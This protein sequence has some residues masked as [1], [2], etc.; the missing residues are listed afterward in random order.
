MKKIS[1]H[2]KNFW[3]NVI[4]G[5]LFSLGMTMATPIILTAYVKKFTSNEYLINLIPAI[6]ILGMTIPQLFMARHVEARARNKNLMLITGVFQR[7][8]L[9]IIALATLLLHNQ[10]P[11][12]VLTVFFIVFAIKQFS[13]G[14]NMP[15]WLEMVAKLVPQKSRGRLFSY[16]RFFGGL[17]GLGGAVIAQRILTSVSFPLNF[18]LLFFL[19]FVL[20]GLSIIFLFFIDEKPSE[21]VPKKLSFSAYMKKIPGVLRGDRNYA[22]Y[23]TGNVIL[24]MTT[25]AGSLFFAFGI[26]RLAL[27]DSMVGTISIINIL[28]T[29]LSALVFGRTGDRYGHK[30]NF[31]IS[32]TLSLTGL[33]LLIGLNSLPIFILATVLQGMAASCTMVSQN[34]MQMEFC[35]ERDRP[36]YITLNKTITAPF[37]FAAPMLG[38]FIARNFGYTSVFLAVMALKTVFLLYFGLVVREPRN[39]PAVSAQPAKA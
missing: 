32:T 1:R 12:M 24:A 15:V 17:L 11:A 38:S 13:N 27:S 4:D 9:L 21:H 10:S 30:L 2:D 33:S 19:F 31:M 34:A 29:T 39:V 3:L 28:T 14:M 6:T 26:D 35:G 8:P 16:R 37:S 18:S 7:V 20:A 25:M 22:R 36:T 23:V 5:S